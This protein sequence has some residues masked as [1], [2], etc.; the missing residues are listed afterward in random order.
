METEGIQ[1]NVSF[2]T[3]S[4]EHEI[5]IFLTRRMKTTGTADC[6]FVGI[7]PLFQKTALIESERMPID[8][9]MN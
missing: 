6:W 1:V 9:R 2:S 4:E 8:T 5:K 3:E 7:I